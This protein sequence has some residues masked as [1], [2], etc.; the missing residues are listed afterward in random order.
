MHSR[1]GQTLIEALA[2]LSVLTIGFLGIFGLLAQS[3]SAVRTS[4]EETTA[5]YLAAEGIELS[6]SML[7]RAMYNYPNLGIADEWPCFPTIPGDYGF[8]Y[9]ALWSGSGCA[10]LSSAPNQ[11]QSQFLLL[12]PATGLYSYSAGNPTDFKRD[13]NVTAA[14][15]N[16]NELIILS[17]VTWNGGRSQVQ[18]EDHFYN[19]LP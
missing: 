19:W 14:S 4:S 13:V 18:L 2:A 12:D 9:T 17:T 3:F 8:D 11:S 1:S 7:D 5:T 10:S 15:G 16:P 6:K